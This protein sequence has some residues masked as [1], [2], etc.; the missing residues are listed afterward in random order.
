MARSTKLRM[1]VIGLGHFAQAAILPAFRHLDDVT[2]TALVS[3]TPTKLTALADRYEVEHAVGYDQLD[4]L[5]ARGAL[6]A[7][8]I[9]LP[10]DLHAEYTLRAARHGV[11]VLCEKPMAPTEADCQRMITACED[12]DVRLMIAYRLHFEVANLTAIDL[13]QG[14]KLGEPRVFSSVFTQQVREHNVR[15]QARAGAGPIYD[16]GVYCINA[17]RY[18]FRD[19]PIEIS[20]MSFA[21]R[22]DPRFQH[23]DE[24]VAVTLR[25]PGDKLATFAV[26]FGAHDRAHYQVVC[27][28]GVFTLDDAYEYVADM[29]LTVQNGVGPR[30]RTFHK[31]DQIAA[32]I[33]Y[34]VRCVQGGIDP[35]PSGHEGLADVRIIEAVQRAIESR[36]TV[37]LD[38]I[39]R[40]RRPDLDQEI[41]VAPHGMPRLVEVES[42]AQ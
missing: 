29:K 27:T 25:F 16:I 13:A 35:E 36:R 40:P 17:A 2:L 37:T 42:A 10:N 15:T 3:G 1:G 30:S 38:P 12:A 34:F 9:A 8:Y 32:E 39:R 28:D 4:A 26:S 11:H 20:A 24:A 33:E 22:E 23:V 41:R 18:L 6:D 14:G 5:L 31:R 19:E 7:V 21:N